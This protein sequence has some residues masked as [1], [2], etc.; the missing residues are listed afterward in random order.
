[1]HDQG[2]TIG[3]SMKTKKTVLAKKMAASKQNGRRLSDSKLPPSYYDRKLEAEARSAKKKGYG[4][5]D[6]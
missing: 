6:F 2:L 4:T 5:P 1:M 3:C